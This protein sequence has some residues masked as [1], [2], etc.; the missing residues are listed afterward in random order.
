[1]SD[2][3]V[4]QRADANTTDDK[5]PRPAG[6]P[7]EAAPPGDAAVLDPTQPAAVQPAV[8]ISPSP[9]GGLFGLMHLGGKIRSFWGETEDR[10]RTLIAKVGVAEF[11]LPQH[12][13]DALG[14]SSLNAYAD[15]QCLADNH[16]SLQSDHA[17][18]EEQLA[19]AKAECERL[20][21]ENA[22]LSESLQQSEAAS[23][24]SDGA[25]NSSEPASDTR[26]TSA[27]TITSS[28]TEHIEGDVEVTK[29]GPQPGQIGAK[30]AE[31]E[32]QSTID[33]HQGSGPSGGT[34]SVGGA[35]NIQP[36]RE[37]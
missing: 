11:S 31:H 1:M 10:M 20:Q 9:S 22:R 19:A 16:S 34:G 33:E 2:A 37:A 27:D 6:V 4:A 5:G 15:H 28:T 23:D 36:Q 32:D 29:L 17:A 26:E 12:Q 30:A 24:L 21:G 13:A 3:V 7:P 14:H 8:I 25:A 18:L 35:A